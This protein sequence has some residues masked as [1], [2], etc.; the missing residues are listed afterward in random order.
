MTALVVVAVVAVDAI[1]EESEPAGHPPGRSLGRAAAGAATR[2]SLV[3]VEGT[4]L[5]AWVAVGPSYDDLTR[6]R[7][8]TERERRL[9]RRYEIVHNF[10][11]FT[12]PFPSAFDRFVVAG[13]RTLL[14]SW[15]GTTA[16]RILGGGADAMIRARARA[17]RRLR[18]PVL[19]RF[20]WEMNTRVKAAWAEPD[21]FVEVW[22]YV[23]RIFDEEGAT[24]VAWV[25]C[26]TTE[27]FAANAEVAERY[28]P[29]ADWVDWVAADGYN[30]AP[31]K[32]GAA[33][34]SF[35]TTFADFYRWA[36]RTGKPTMIAEVGVLERRPG[37]K[38]AWL[39]ELAPVLRTRFPRVGA[40]VY[41]DTRRIV[42]GGVRDW[43]IDTSASSLAAFDR[44]AGDLDAGLRM[45][46]Q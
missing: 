15:N 42:D 29:G 4:R 34:R 2:A 13:D 19:L 24:N 6:A 32:P 46:G 22:R 18:Q 9:G 45:P 7:L 39:D 41:F 17:L 25:W 38:A 12:D 28:W 1:P 36:A 3:P 23:H 40:L 21:E 14:L 26:P 5:G 30:F 43:R 35:A 27:A 10:H 44:L 33:Y 37:E 16:A 20:W 31:A 8:V 11:P